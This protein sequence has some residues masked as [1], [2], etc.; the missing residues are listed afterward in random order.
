MKTRDALKNEYRQ[1]DKEKS[2]GVPRVENGIDM[3][4]RNQYKPSNA[5]CNLIFS[6][7]TN[8]NNDRSF[9]FYKIKLKTS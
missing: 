9:I 4:S 3:S 2:P 7:S 1:C 8:D 5:N 6:M